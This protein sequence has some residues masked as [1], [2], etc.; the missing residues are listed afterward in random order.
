MAKDLRLLIIEDNEALFDLY[1]MVLANSFDIDTAETCAQGIEKFLENPNVYDAVITDLHHQG[2]NGVDVVEA[3]YNSSNP[4]IP[5]YVVTG[6]SDEET[7]ERARKLVVSRYIEKPFSFTELG[8][9]V[10]RDAKQIKREKL[11]Y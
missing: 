10:L 2:K 1:D 6:G 3:V 8:S 4:R 7:M 9:Q 11:K 5:V